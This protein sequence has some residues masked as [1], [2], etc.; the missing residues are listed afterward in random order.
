MGMVGGIRVD[1][2]VIELSG[3]RGGKCRWDILNYPHI[4]VN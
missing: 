2:R 1:N 4:P 3:Y